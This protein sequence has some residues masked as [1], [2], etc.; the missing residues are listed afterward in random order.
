MVDGINGVN[1]LEGV[2]SH[3]FGTQHKLEFDLKFYLEYDNEN[4]CLYCGSGE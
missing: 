2:S 3:R 4:K 1:G